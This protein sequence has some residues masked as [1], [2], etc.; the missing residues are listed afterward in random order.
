MAKKK[1]TQPTKFCKDCKWFINDKYHSMSFSEKQICES[2][3][4]N[5]EID[6]VTG[7]PLYALNKANLV[8][9]EQCRGKWWETK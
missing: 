7:K 4:R 1:D 6:L 3:K 5:I 8:R 9:A 2:P